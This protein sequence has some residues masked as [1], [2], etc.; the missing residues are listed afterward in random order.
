MDDRRGQTG[1]RATDLFAG[2]LASSILEEEMDRT[3]E[4]PSHL[5][6]E[7]LVVALAALD[8]NFAT[9]LDRRP[10]GDRVELKLEDSRVIIRFTDAGLV[11]SVTPTGRPTVTRELPY[12]QVDARALALATIARA[13]GIVG[14]PDIREG[15]STTSAPETWSGHSGQPRDNE[16]A[17]RAHPE[18]QK[19]E[20]ENLADDPVQASIQSASQH[21][22]AAAAAG[23]QVSQALTS[24]RRHIGRSRLIRL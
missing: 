12:E 20:H 23:S 8:E 17:E 15:R 18:F 14:Q 16:D 3:R 4:K 13:P 5:Q 11:L 22:N 19:A 2:A 6:L 24:A 1:R 21:L 9:M 7:R 10:S